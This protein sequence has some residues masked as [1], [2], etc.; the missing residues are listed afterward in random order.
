MKKSEITFD[1]SV[2]K[3]SVPIEDARNTNYFK[4][5]FLSVQI[6]SCS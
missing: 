6:L 2:R 1:L 3:R 5:S 4:R